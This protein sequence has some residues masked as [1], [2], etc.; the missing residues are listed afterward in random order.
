M[1]RKGEQEACDYLLGRGHSIVARNWRSSH[2]ELDII[3]LCGNVLHIVEVKSRTAPVV[4][5]PQVNVNKAKRERVVKASLAFLNS[6]YRRN[7]PGN[8]EVCFDVITVVFS[9]GGTK[10]EYFPQAFI[11][12]YV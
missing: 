2:L 12:T 3:S 1:G 9:S 10:I 11:P 6:A 5:E 4:A 8:L 7:L